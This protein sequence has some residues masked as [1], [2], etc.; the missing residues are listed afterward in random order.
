MNIRILLIFLCFTLVQP[1]S[2]TELKANNANATLTFAGEHA[3]MSFTGQ[4][5]Q[6]Q[7]TLLL[8]PANSPKIT[9]T[10]Q[11]GSAR[12]GDSMYDETLPEGDWFNAEQFP[13]ASFSS[14]SIQVVDGGYWVEGALQIK[15]ISKPISFSLNRISAGF[16]ATFDI[17]RLAYRIG[18]ESDPE[19]EWVSQFIKMNLLIPA[20]E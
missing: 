7:A 4:F 3:G 20:A 13:D 16:E 11:I 10:F 18:L 17:D 1:S 14:T 15:D 9:A 2:A 8:P 6:W 5:N 12:T 19:A